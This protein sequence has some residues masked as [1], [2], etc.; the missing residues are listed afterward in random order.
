MEY[1]T[2]G[3]MFMCMYSMQG[4]DLEVKYTSG[5]TTH[6]RRE[7]ASRSR[8]QLNSNKPTMHTSQCKANMTW[9]NSCYGNTWQAQTKK[10]YKEQFHCRFGQIVFK[11]KKSEVVMISSTV[12]GRFLGHFHWNSLVSYEWFFRVYVWDLLIIWTFLP[13]LSGPKKQST[14]LVLSE[15]SKDT[16]QTGLECSNPLF[17]WP[18]ILQ[19]DTNLCIQ[20]ENKLFQWQTLNF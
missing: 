19:N 17:Y 9:K 13:W 14:L 18:G 20:V 16:E 8:S 7:V 6:T 11:Q 3:A 5:S 4:W 15:D 2:F 12:T 10:R 1:G